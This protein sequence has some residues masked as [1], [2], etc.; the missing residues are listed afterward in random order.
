MK[1][2]TNPYFFTYLIELKKKL[3]EV[4]S[5]NSLLAKQIAFRVLSGYDSD[6]MENFNIIIKLKLIISKYL[7]QT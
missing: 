5:K 4:L 6:L 7:K 3:L 2:T 1:E